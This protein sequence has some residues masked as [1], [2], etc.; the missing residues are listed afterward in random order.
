MR[1]FLDDDVPTEVARVL[2]REG[3]EATELRDVLPV[4]ASETRGVRG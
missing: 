2:R 3:H 4:T 1:F